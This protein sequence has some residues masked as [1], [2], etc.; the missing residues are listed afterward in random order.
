M[1][2]LYRHGAASEDSKVDLTP[3][4]DVVFIMLIF[5]VVTASFV[6]ESGY[7]L[8]RPEENQQPPL[9]APK[10]ILFTIN[11]NNEVFLDQ[12]RIDARSVRAN[13][14]RMSAANPEASIIIQ[15]D[16]KAKNRVITLVSNQ[17]R[18]AGVN[19]IS[20]IIQTD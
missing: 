18:E 14:E 20:L 4:L 9:D 19:A 13:V 5:F 11:A 2:K 16:P 12:R 15:A 17:S 1:S 7:Q 3:M 6:K 10:N 8:T